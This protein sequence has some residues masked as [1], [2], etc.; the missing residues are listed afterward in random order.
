MLHLQ[1]LGPDGRDR[2]LGLGERLGQLVG[3]GRAFERDGRK[4][5]AIYLPVRREGE[6]VHQ[7]ER[8]RDHV[9]RQ[10][11][12]QVLAQRRGRQ[13][14]SVG[15]QLRTHV[16]LGGLVPDETAALRRGPDR[17]HVAQLG[18][19]QQR[20]LLDHHVEAVTLEQLCDRLHVVALIDLDHR[21]ADLRP[22]VRIEPAQHIQLA[23]FDV[24]LEQVDALDPLL[25][26]DARERAQPGRYRPGPEPVLDDVAHV[27]HEAVVVRGPALLIEHVA[28]DHLALRFGIGI[29]ARE[30][31]QA[32]EPGEI[33]RPAL[34]GQ[35]E[36]QAAHAPPSTP[37]RRVRLETRKGGGIGLAGDDAEV[38]GQPAR[39]HR[40]QPDVGADVDDAVAVPDRDAV[41]QIGL[42]DEDL[43]VDVLGLVAVQVRDGRAI[44]QHV[45]RLPTP[46]CLVR[47]LRHDVR[48]QLLAARRVVVRPN[49]GVAHA[50]LRTQRALDLAQLDPVAVQ[51]D[52]VVDAAA[53]LEAPVRQHPRH[54]AGPIEAIPGT[55]STGAERIR[56]ELLRREVRAAE[57]APPHAAA[58]DVQL[59]LFPDGRGP[60]ARIEDVHLAV[61]QGAPERQR[62]R[63][64]DR[65]LGPDFVGQNTDGRLRGTV[66]IVDLAARSQRPQ[67]G[68]PV[69]PRGLAAQH[70]ARPGHHGFRM[71]TGLQGGEMR[72]HDLQD[73]DPLALEVFR[74]QRWILGPLLR[75]HVQAAPRRE[76]REHDGVAE[77]GRD[78]RHRR[79]IHARLE[80]QPLRNSQNVVDDVAMGDADALGAAGGAARVDHVREVVGAHGRRCRGGLRL[81]ISVQAYGPRAVDREAGHEA[82]LCDHH[83]DARVREHE[84]DP[85]L[86]VARVDGQVRRPGLED[87][88]NADDQVDRAVDQQADDGVRAD[89]PSPQV[90]RQ[91]PGAPVELAVRQALLLEHD[92]HVIGGAMRLRLDQLMQAEIGQSEHAISSFMISLAPA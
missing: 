48:H 84:G 20:I 57:I 51:L 67:P 44:G 59:T 3:V 36:R 75:H 33:R 61:G 90:V 22:I 80:S 85:L 27:R 45:R 4:C 72:R 83:R 40:E 10:T 66:V 25:R 56:D 6:L 49:D 28:R 62:A 60:P 9:L 12:L 11:R 41:P 46:Q 87:A 92:R 54:V 15:G 29:K 89:T 14:F 82:R 1:E 79:V 16:R 13:D 35:A 7:D 26:D 63:L 43:V 32:L 21:L 73:V 42:L 5:V 8:R 70:E 91:P 31:R 37:R 30:Q 39:E 47:P 34:A 17:V 69:Q 74:E 23:L 24:D 53:K 50:A 65:H 64:G 71:K 38:T 19:S 2:L 52:L 55:R 58:A 68:D 88:E 86:R 18:V 77:I 78:G 76:R 81:K